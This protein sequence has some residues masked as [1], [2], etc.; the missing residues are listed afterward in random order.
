MKAEIFMNR[1]ANRPTDGKKLAQITQ[2]SI[3]T[4]IFLVL[5]EIGRVTVSIM[6]PDILPEL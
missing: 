1:R 5:A 3:S 4:E 6:K 2:T